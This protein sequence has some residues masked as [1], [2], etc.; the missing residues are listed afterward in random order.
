MYTNCR[1]PSSHE[2]WEEGCQCQPQSID[3]GEEFQSKEM[4]KKCLTISCQ[5]ES[6][7][8]ESVVACA[9]NK[10]NIKQTKTI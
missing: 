5:T 4:G 2:S 6:Q 3:I 8:E 1:Q 7:T 9:H 10:D